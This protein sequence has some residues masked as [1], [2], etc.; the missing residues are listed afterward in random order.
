MAFLKQAKNSILFSRN[1][2]ELQTRSSFMLFWPTNA[3]LMK[4]KP[5]LLLLLKRLR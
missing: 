2:A 5:P 4:G 1:F 3:M